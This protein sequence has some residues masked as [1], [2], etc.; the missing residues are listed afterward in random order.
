[1]QKLQ[2]GHTTFGS[3]PQTIRDVSWVF[4]V[5][6]RKKNY[7]HKFFGNSFSSNQ[8]KLTVL[9]HDD[10]SFE[11]CMRATRQ[12]W[13]KHVK[14]V[15][16]MMYSCIWWYTSHYIYKLQITNYNH[17]QKIFNSVFA[18]P[19]LKFFRKHRYYTFF[20]ILAKIVWYPSHMW[21]YV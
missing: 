1:M 18:P 12:Q 8:I 6:T 4:I 7:M 2:N 13:D 5:E 16:R 20:Q 19:C 17:W 21:L 9:I 3:Y 15:D 10:S 11:L 14:T